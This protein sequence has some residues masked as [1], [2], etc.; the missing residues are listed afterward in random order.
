VKTFA[1][2]PD[3]VS[4][5]D[6]MGVHAARKNSRVS[7]GWHAWVLG[8]RLDI[9]GSGRVRRDD[10][11]VFANSIGVHP[12]TWERW[13]NEARNNNLLM[14]IQK[15]DGE[16][17][18]ILPSPARAAKSMGCAHVGSR[19]VVMSAAALIGEGWR[20]RVFSAWEDGKQISREQIQKHLDIP[21]ST[22]ILHGYSR[23]TSNYQ[24]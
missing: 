17:W 2:F 6:R 7:H 22:V 20:A 15:S 21:V 13:I 14:D 11:R 18:F 9:E 5:Y 12:R 3:T 10:L 1:C 4:F 24:S 8:K 23:N 16:W 19:K